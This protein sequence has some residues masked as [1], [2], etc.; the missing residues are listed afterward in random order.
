MHIVSVSS[1]QQP[2]W[3]SC[4]TDLQAS[5]QFNNAIKYTFIKYSLIQ[6]NCGLCK[7]VLTAVA[8]QCLITF[9][10]N[11]SAINILIREHIKSL[12]DILNCK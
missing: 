2:K 9:A 11:F 7:N 10:D 12:K 6:S 5:G 3:S 1:K 4:W 8:K